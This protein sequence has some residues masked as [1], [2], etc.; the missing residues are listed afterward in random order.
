M[1]T[2]VYL[3]D[4]ELDGEVHFL[5]VDQD[6]Y[7]R[8]VLCF[9]RDTCNQLESRARTLRED[10]FDYLLESGTMI[11]GIRV[12]G[13]GYSA[14][15]TIAHHKRLGLGALKIL[16]VDSRRSSLVHEAE[17]M[18][19]A[20]PSGLPP[21]PL[22]YR[23]FYVFYELLPPHRCIGFAGYL[24]R[25]IE[26]RD[27]ELIVR[28][29]RRLL[30]RLW[31]L[32]SIGVDHAEINRPHGHVFICHD[33]PRILD[34]ESARL[35]KKPSNVTSMVSYL[36][37]RFSRREELVEILGTRLEELLNALRNY[38][39]TRLQDAYL[40]ILK[41]MGLLLSSPS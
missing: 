38:K 24:E 14:V 30:D 40:S 15:V 22:L 11:L 33:T 29:L 12:L 8:R 31:I 13:K 25:L 23:D 28:V 4:A 5:D 35:T 39:E 32:D 34:W 37:Y 26:R 16:R 2:R 17:I 27:K 3:E 20:L 36:T 19:K 21:K 7:I 6:S 10:G 1:A 9:P 18:E 41:A